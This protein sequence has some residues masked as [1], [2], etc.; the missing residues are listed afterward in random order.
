MLYYAFGVGM[1]KLYK[2]LFLGRMWR[3]IYL[4]RLGEPLIYNFAS[5]FVFLFGSYSTKIRYDLIPRQPYAFGIDFA[6]RLARA[7]GIDKLVI[8]EFGVAGGAGLLNM[9]DIAGR[10][11]KERGGVD[12]QIVGFDSG[13]GMPAP[14]D[15]RDHPEKYKTGDYPTGNREKLLAQLPANAKIYFGDVKDTVATFLKEIP[16]GYRIGFISVD[17]DYYSSAKACLEILKQDQS[18]Y[19]PSVPM[20]FDD[21]REIDHNEYCGELLAIKEF[22][23]EDNVYRK[24]TKITDLR[25]CRLFQRATW[26]DQMYFGHVFDSSYR[27]SRGGAPVILDNPYLGS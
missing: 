4:E 1:N 26:I 14:L 20:Y 2:K 6:Y 17:V 19:L 24:I 21:V 3:R 5:L 13:I 12:F 11:A 8:I 7:R 23:N 25:R 9:I 15:F 22:N 18:H 10:V 16:S 27:A